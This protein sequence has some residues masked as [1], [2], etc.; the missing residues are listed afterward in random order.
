[1]KF[2]A[3]I[4]GEDGIPPESQIEAAHECGITAIRVYDI[5]HAEEVVPILKRTGTSLIGGMHIDGEELLKDWR[6]QVR[7]EELARYHELG[8]RLDAICVGNEL[9]EGGND[10]NA[11]RFTARLS[12]AMANV[13]DTYRRWLREHGL[14]TPVTYASEAIVLDSESRFHEWLWP[15]IDA[16]DVVSI[17]LYPMGLMD[18]VGFGA[19]EENRRFLQDRRVRRMRFA[20]FE[21]HLRR[22]LEQLA[23]VNKPFVFTETGFPSAV[24]YRIENEKLIV[25][26]SDNAR[27]AEAMEEF[28][29]LIR[30]VDEDYDGLIQGLYFYEWRDNL[31]HGAIWDETASPIHTSFG[32]CD[33]TGRPK[34]DIRRLTALNSQKTVR[35][36]TSTCTCH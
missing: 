33:R 30:R 29:A 19:F 7:I 26:E 27:F 14:S 15:L 6:S 8:V 36:G 3:W 18:W 2:G 34:L 23:S 22:V 17:N 5:G 9:R 10:P 31:H 28:V 20:W 11:R 4:H 25:P 32:L 35:K 12:F 21:L 24:G 13:L 1:M 16:S